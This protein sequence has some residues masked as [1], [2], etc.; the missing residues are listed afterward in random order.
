MTMH[1]MEALTHTDVPDDVATRPIVLRRRTIDRVLVALGAVVAVVLAAAGGLLTWGSTFADDYVGR[2]LESQNIF[3]PDEASLTEDGRSDLVGYADEQVTTGDEAEAYASYIDGHLEG[4]ADGQTYA[5][6]GS[7]QRAA[8][9][10]VDDAVT[11]DAPDDEVA[12]LQADA[13]AITTQRDSLFRG[14]TLRGL[15]LSTFA[16]STIG[17]IA[18]IASIVAFVA[19][20]AMAVLVGAGLVHLRGHRVH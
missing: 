17:S 13:D 12:T 9:A 20:G 6:L 19:A 10:A 4:I 5:D 18:F 16:W 14:E 7:V 15:L 1:L 2:E 11:A 3:F 8:N